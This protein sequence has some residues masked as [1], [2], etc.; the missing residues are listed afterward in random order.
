MLLIVNIIGH[1]LPVAFALSLSHE[2][3]VYA[4]LLQVHKKNIIFVNNSYFFL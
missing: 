4:K 1:G 2:T 3:G